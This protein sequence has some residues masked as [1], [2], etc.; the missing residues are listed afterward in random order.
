M[1]P[2]KLQCITF[3]KLGFPSEELFSHPKSKFSHPK[4]SSDGKWDSFSL[5]FWVMLKISQQ[6]LFQSMS[7]VMSFSYLYPGSRLYKLWC[8][9]MIFFKFLKI[10]R[11]GLRI[12]F[13]MKIPY[14][15]IG[16]IKSIN[17]QVEK[18]HFTWIMLLKS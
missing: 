15:S 17:L 16:L 2:Q 18:I 3:L 1:D 12:K 13:L 8:Y 10:H 5:F 7:V 11:Y 9:N 6:M 14:L 4:S